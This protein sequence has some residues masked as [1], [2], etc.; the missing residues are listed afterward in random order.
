MPRKSRQKCESIFF[1]L[2]EPIIPCPAWPDDMKNALITE[3]DR[4][5]DNMW[6][7]FEI[8]AKTI[9]RQRRQFAGYRGALFYIERAQQD[10]AF[11]TIKICQMLIVDVDDLIEKLRAAGKFDQA[12]QDYVRY[13]DLE[14]PFTTPLDACLNALYRIRNLC[15]RYLNAQTVQSVDP[16]EKADFVDGDFWGFILERTQLEEEFTKLARRFNLRHLLQS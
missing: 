9:D 13:T 2:P 7:K 3:I 14:E 10:A 5:M 11:Y 15:E 16:N 6:R 8:G 4:T 12:A 1:D